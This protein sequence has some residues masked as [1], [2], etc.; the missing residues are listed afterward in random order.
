MTIAVL[1]N[2]NVSVLHITI[3]KVMRNTDGCN[4]GI[5]NTIW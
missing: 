4:S 3:N 2:S 5:T 1:G